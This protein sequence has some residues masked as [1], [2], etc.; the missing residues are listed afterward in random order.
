VHSLH[1]VLS[2]ASR[3]ERLSV[4]QQYTQAALWSSRTP[5]TACRTS[6]TVHQQPQLWWLHRLPAT[7]CCCCCT[8]ASTYTE[9]QHD[10]GSNGASRL[11]SNATSVRQRGLSTAIPAAG[12]TFALPAIQLPRWLCATHASADQE[13]VCATRTIRGRSLWCTGC[14]SRDG[15]EHSPVAKRIRCEG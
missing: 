4:K 1:H 12:A 2:S 3:T 11:L 14:R 9:P 7:C 5:T 15:S 13:S 10:G 8:A 6:T